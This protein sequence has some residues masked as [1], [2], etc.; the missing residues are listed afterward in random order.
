MITFAEMLKK[1]V[2]S[3]C[4]PAP[5]ALFVEENLGVRVATFADTP[6]PGLVT[7]LTLGISGHVLTQPLSGT[8]IRQEL[9]TCVDAK[10]RELPW[11]EV[12][13]A[14]AKV[15]LE[16]HTAIRLGEVL[17]PA[18][19]LFPEVRWCNATAL[20]CAPPAFFD[21]DFS[22]PTFDE[23]SMIFAE[24]IPIT[25][26]EAEWVQRFGWSAFFDRVNA[27]E[28]DILNLRRP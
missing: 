5:S 28:I 3:F 20:L 21:A 13:L 11:H 22:E 19:A 27:G 7:S 23:I 4:G 17:G 18:G 8:K 16:R 1:H 2:D 26:S 9:L 15:L 25:T 10:Y 24:L 12:L 14:T 6:E